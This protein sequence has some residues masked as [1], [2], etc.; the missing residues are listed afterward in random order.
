MKCPFC[1]E[2]IDASFAICNHCGSTIGSNSPYRN[3]PSSKSGRVGMEFCGGS[4]GFFFRFLWMGLACL[5]VF[6]APIA[7][8]SFYHWLIKNIHMN[9]GSNIT[10][11]GTTKEMVK[12]ILIGTGISLVITISRI[13]FS[14]QTYIL[15]GSL[16]LSIAVA[17]FIQSTIISWICRNIHFGDSS[18]FFKGDYFV[19]FGWNVL[20]NLVSVVAV[21]KFWAPQQLA[22]LILIAMAGS[23]WVVAAFNRWI[24]R[25]ISGD[26]SVEF[27]GS[28]WGILWRIIF[29]VLSCVLIIPIPWTFTWFARWFIRQLTIQKYAHANANETLSDVATDSARPV[30]VDIS[31]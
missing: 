21:L 15:I 8:K 28:G 30:I 13:Y 24:C 7:I 4:L 29:Y 3:G 25:N 16:I 12:Y 2:E 22:I 10:F 19:I 5:L 17:S 20:L 14:N 23:A 11:S 31:G 9:D 26:V 6:P 1:K 27:S 18:I